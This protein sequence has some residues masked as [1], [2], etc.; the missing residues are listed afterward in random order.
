MEHPPGEFL[1]YD[2]ER[3][4]WVKIGEQE[5]R[6]SFKV[7]RHKVD[8]QTAAMLLNKM[9]GPTPSDRYIKDLMELYNEGGTNIRQGTPKT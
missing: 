3:K 1:K 7:G 2:D 9:P 6:E 4:E 8:L 5:Y